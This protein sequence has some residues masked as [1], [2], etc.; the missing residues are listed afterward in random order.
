MGEIRVIMEGTTPPFG[1]P[2]KGGELGTPPN[3]T[4]ASSLEVRYPVR[5]TPA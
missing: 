3:I 2:S 1:H 5:Q 4:R